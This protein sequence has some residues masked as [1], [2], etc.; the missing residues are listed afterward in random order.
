M[1]TVRFAGGENATR[2]LLVPGYD[3]SLDGAVHSWFSLPV[4]IEEN[5]LIV[6]VHAYTPYA[7]A[8]QGM[9]DG[10]KSTFDPAN[11]QDC[12]DINT[13][14]KKLYN[15][16]IRQGIP[17]VLGEYG[18]RDKDNLQ[19]RAD[20]TAYYVAAAS[21]HGIPCFYWDNNAFSGSGELFGLLNRA[22]NTFAYPEILESMM[23]YTLEKSR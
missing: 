19:S 16:Y 20:F 9:A 12:K 10:G 11:L 7:F 14:M 13:L 6:S 15:T 8:L 4:D 18:A 22:T 3:A 23:A 2:Y 17:V 5:R 21:A 1:D